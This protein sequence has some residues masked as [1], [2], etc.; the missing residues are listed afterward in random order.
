ML[1]VGGFSESEYLQDRIKKEFSDE[2][3]NISVPK[4]PISSIMKGGK[5][6]FLNYFFKIYPKAIY[7]FYYSREI[8]SFRKNCEESY[9]KMDLWY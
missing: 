8:W 4:N 5:L 7:F 3:P 9:I 6:T 2:V 1:L